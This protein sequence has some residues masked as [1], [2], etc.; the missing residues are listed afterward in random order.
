M[1]DSF[2]GA[3][4]IQLLLIF[5]IIF[6]SFL[7][8]ALNYSKAFRIKNGVINILEQYQYDGTESDPAREKVKNYVQGMAYS[9]DNNSSVYDEC[10]NTTDI[11]ETF[12]NGV[13]I[14]PMGD[15]SEFGNYYRVITYIPIE[16]NFF[17]LNFYISVSGET[18]IIN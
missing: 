10:M 17:D 5:I 7:A 12:L 4:M 8:I 11:K 14:I 1:R 2:G 9:Y 16:F 13:C 6:V 15:G 18:K 3:F